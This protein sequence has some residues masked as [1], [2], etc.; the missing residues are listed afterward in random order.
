MTAPATP[1]SAQTYW[2]RPASKCARLPMAIFAGLIALWAI[3]SIFWPDTIGSFQDWNTVA[4]PDDFRTIAVT[5]AS[6]SIASFIP[7]NQGLYTIEVITGVI[8][9]ALTIVLI[10]ARAVYGQSAYE[11]TANVVMAIAIGLLALTAILS[12]R[13]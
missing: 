2:G 1:S 3:G 7:Q 9:L 6:L 4:E 10:Y 8:A 5:F 12:N 11:P 13:S